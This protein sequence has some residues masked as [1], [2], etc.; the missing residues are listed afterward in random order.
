MGPI[1]MHTVLYAS[2]CPS[3]RLQRDPRA[4]GA[5]L[6]HAA[7]LWNACCWSARRNPAETQDMAW[8]AMPWRRQRQRKPVWLYGCMERR[9]TEIE[10]EGQ[11][12][13]EWRVEGGGRRVEGG[14]CELGGKSG[15]DDGIDPG[16]GQSWT[17][18]ACPRSLSRRRT[19]SNRTLS[20]VGRPPSVRTD[21]QSTS[22][23]SPRAIP[24]ARCST[25]M[26]E[27]AATAAAAARR[28]VHDAAL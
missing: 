10:A 6:Y 2:S 27:P 28:C 26:R 24:R 4:P 12:G 17:G 25:G 15:L 18:S 22:L 21:R 1:C 11:Q 3:A 19:G 9:S 8:H 23:E 13:G 20:Q 5:T 7:L 16:T 14:G